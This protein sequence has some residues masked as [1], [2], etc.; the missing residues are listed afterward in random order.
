MRQSIGLEVVSIFPN[1]ADYLLNV[2]IH[3]PIPFDHRHGKLAIMDIAGRTVLEKELHFSELNL[4]LDTRLWSP[5]LYIYELELPGISLKNGK[6]EV[7]H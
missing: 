4:T 5:G 1:P 2:V 6:F 3:S 7:Q